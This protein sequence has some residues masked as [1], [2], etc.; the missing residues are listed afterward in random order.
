MQGLAYGDWFPG[1]TAGSQ[2]GIVDADEAGASVATGDINNDGAADVIIGAPFADPGGRDIASQTYV[3][4]GPF[5]T[6]TVELSSADL[7][8]NGIDP[9]DLSGTGVAAGDVNNDGLADLVIGA[10]SGDPA[11]GRSGAGETYVIFGETPSPSTPIPS[12]AWWGM[13]AMAGAISA[14]IL[15]R[16]R[17]RPLILVELMPDTS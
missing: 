6:G 2:A 5:V 11:P 17:S 14:L 8:F 15:W 12:V 7:T 10:N 9:I 13:V 4:F 3:L 1:G 16:T